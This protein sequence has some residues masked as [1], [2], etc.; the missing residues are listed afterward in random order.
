MT[1]GESI[2]SPAATVS[3]ASTIIV[4]EVSFRMNPLAPWFRARTT[5]SGDEWLQLLA[6]TTR[7][8]L[9][10]LVAGLWRL[11]RREIE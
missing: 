11:L 2:G 1:L 10:P 6:T 5:I 9:L 3:I 7:W 4:G 8:I